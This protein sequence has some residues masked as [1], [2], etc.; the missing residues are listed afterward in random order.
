MTTEEKAKAYDEVLIKGSRLWE[1]GVITRENY[2][3][4]FPELKESEDER[5]RK[6]IKKELESK[7]VVD[8]IVNNVM[9]D[10]ALA[11]L[12][13]QGEKKTTW[14][15]E[16]EEPKRGS[17]ILLVMQSGTPIV[18]KIIE[19]N[20]TFNHG[21]RWAYIDDLIENQC[22]HKPADE[23]KP[24]FKVGDWVVN[25]IT[26]NVEQIIKVTSNEY[27]CSGNLIVSF[28]NQH[29]LRKWTIQ[30]AKDGDV[31]L[32][33]ATPEGD[34]ECPFI[35]KEIGKDGIIRFHAALLQSERFR[36]ADGITN[37]MG[38]ANAG[39]H[40]P[41]TKEQRELLFQKMEEAGYEW[42][43]EKKESKKIGQKSTWSED[44][45]EMFDAIIADIK[46]TQKAHAH[47]V[48]QVV[49]EREIDWLKSI[50]GKLQTKQEWGKK[51]KERYIS[52]LQRLSTGNPEQPETINSKWFKEHVYPQ[53]TWKPS[54]EQMIALR[55]VI[56]G[57][58]YDIEPLVELETKL[59]EL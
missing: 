49:Y 29:L 39:Y 51:D 47:E 27:I 46:F 56:S 18:A 10:K 58:S 25:T 43:E 5:I 13:N 34:K 44:D 8:N 50:K 20:H 40:I 48:N 53:S 23:V 9:A 19:P 52:C 3:Y 30:D 11:W 28:D 31:L 33:P 6:W 57:C 15:N 24:K 55:L 4:I 21:E 7:Y 59:K 12:E 14:H 38:Y 1:C 42:D 37:V 17:L 26:N 41:A 22:E 36:I 16:D 45:E 2:E 54:D 35:F 32:S